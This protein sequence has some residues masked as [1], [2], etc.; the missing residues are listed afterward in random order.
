VGVRD[1]C[2]TSALKWQRGTVIKVHGELTYQVDCEG[3][4]R[5]VHVDHLLPAPAPTGSDDTETSVQGGSQVIESNTALGSPRTN[6]SSLLDTLPVELTGSPT[7][8]SPS[9]L[10]PNDIPVPEMRRSTLVIKKPQRLI[11]ELT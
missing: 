10:L 1:F 6:D 9:V 7:A 5:Q 8:V 4:Q 2:P 11:K 3:H